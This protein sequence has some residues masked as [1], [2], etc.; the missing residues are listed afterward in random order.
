MVRNLVTS[1]IQ[2][3][4]GFKDKGILHVVMAGSHDI[5]EPCLEFNNVCVSVYL[6]AC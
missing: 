3:K 2:F 5:T 4:L 1:L 6:A